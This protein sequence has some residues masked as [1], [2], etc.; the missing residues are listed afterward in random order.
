[1]KGRQKMREKLD[2]KMCKECGTQ[3]EPLLAGQQ[4]C[5]KCVMAKE[6]PQPVDTTDR[7]DATDFAEWFIYHWR[8]IQ[9]IAAEKYGLTSDKERSKNNAKKD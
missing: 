2:V 1:M 8:A 6:P 9:R 4:R 3:F 5:L 7:M